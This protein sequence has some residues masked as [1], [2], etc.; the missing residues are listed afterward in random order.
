MKSKLLFLTLI[1]TAA[2]TT[3]VFAADATATSPQTSVEA[4]T[5]TPDGLIKNLV[6]SMIQSIK[7]QK[8][9]QG[10]G[11]YK[12]ISDLI[13]AKIMP[14]ADLET[15]TKLAMGQ[16]WE[17]ATPEQRSAIM[18]EFK[19]LLITTYT[20]PFARFSDQQISYKPLR[21]L[22]SDTKVIVKTSIVDQG[23]T[24]SLDYRLH[25][26]NQQWKIYDLTI[27]GVGLVSSYKADFAAQINK[28]GIDGLIKFLQTKN[29]K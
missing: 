16:N 12:K 14:Y 7:D 13:E 21:A 22:P 8:L 20:A 25:K 26:I 10:Q 9:N 23:E 24:K 15:T 18:K 11:N 5:T 6:D 27:L 28:S 3:N 2:L 19:N 4:S 29:K 17:K 1:S